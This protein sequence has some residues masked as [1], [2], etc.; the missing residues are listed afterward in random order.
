MNPR[1]LPLSNFEV[2]AT[3]DLDEA[4]EAV[5]RIFCPHDLQ[6]ISGHQAFDARHNVAPLRELTL[7]YVQYGAEVTIDP[8]CL[9]SFYLLKIPLRGQAEIRWGNEVYVA[10]AACASLVSPSKPLSMRWWEDT[11]HLILKLEEATV[12]RH[13]ESLTGISAG[14]RPLEFVPSMPT[15]KG[16]GA[17]V[18]HLMEFM[19]HQL[20][21]GH[22]HLSAP[23]LA[24]AETGMVHML[25]SQLPHSGSNLL[26][27]RVS[28]IAPRA[29][30]RAREFIDA[31]LADDISV[32]DIATAAGLCVR[33]L[34]AAFVRHTGESP[35][36]FV[37][38]RRLEAVHRD[39]SV[40]LPGTTVTAVA[41]RYG[42][43][44]LGRFS[45]NYAGRFGESPSVTLTKAT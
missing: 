45:A 12:L 42:F 19:A 43:C 24:Q 38:A 25:L 13:W 26:Q 34:Q 1:Q 3:D 35:M 14:R 44:H 15:D 30:R 11:P 32:N 5:A 17:A 2:I 21:S 40:A 6:L 20:S 37:R 22:T 16:A 28:D 33:S 7:N 18:K 41:M 29:V 31:H 8:G 39:L 4:R 27:A 9:G 36:A 23:F 10:D